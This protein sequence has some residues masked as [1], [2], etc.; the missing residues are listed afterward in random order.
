MRFGCVCY[1]T[2]CP[3]GCMELCTCFFLKCGSV[4][5][6]T[7]LLS[8]VAASTSTNA[9]GMSVMPIN[10]ERPRGSLHSELEG[11]RPNPHAQALLTCSTSPEPVALGM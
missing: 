8:F 2:L 6:A 1:N 10:L 5:F 11:P 4:V 9:S 3:S 7:I